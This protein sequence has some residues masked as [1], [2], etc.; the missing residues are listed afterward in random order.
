MWASVGTLVSE[1]CPPVVTDILE[2]KV[3]APVKVDA[4]VTLKALL[5]VVVPVPAPIDIVV[6]APP[7]FKVVAV[8]FTRLNVVW[9]V[10]RSPPL[11]SKSEAA[12]IFPLQFKVPLLFVMVHPVSE[13]PPPRCISPVDALPILIA[14]VVPALRDKDVLAVEAEIEGED[15]ENISLVELKVLPFIVPVEIFPL[16][17]N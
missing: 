7:I 5:T 6:P 15:P 9:F 10:V 13:D 16:T 11:I 12:V 8:V 17:V 1:S 14:P 2:L 4:P 3:A